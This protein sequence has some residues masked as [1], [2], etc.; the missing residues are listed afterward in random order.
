MNKKGSKKF[1]EDQEAFTIDMNDPN[2]VNNQKNQKNQQ[3]V[4]DVDDPE[5]KGAN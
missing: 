5:S 4:E 1:A 2:N 3:R